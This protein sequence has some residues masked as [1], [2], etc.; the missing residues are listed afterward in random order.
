MV[1]SKVRVGRLDQVDHGR[2]DVVTVESSQCD[3]PFFFILGPIL[4]HEVF[5]DKKRSKAIIIRGG[6]SI[7]ASL[8]RN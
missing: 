4:S 2:L 8:Q 3:S 1:S 6:V 7:L 5:L